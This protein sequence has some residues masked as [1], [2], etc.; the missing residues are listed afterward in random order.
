MAG[1]LGGERPLEAQVRKLVVATR[2]PGKVREFRALLADLPLELLPAEGAPEVQETGTTFA[3][4]AALKARAIARW[5]GCWALGED[6]GIEVDALDGRPG[7][8]S[9]R[10]AGENSTEGE[11]NSRLLELLEG[12]PAERRTARYRAVV[13]IAAPD[14]RL[15]L[16]EGKCEGV[17]LTTP[18]GTGGFGY[19]PLFYLPER[20][21]TMA[22]LPLSEKNRI[23]HRAR[24]MHAARAVL[25]R[26][27]GLTDS[28]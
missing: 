5:A 3:E 14:G 28:E 22:E 23:S 20:G 13:A 4:N 25:E 1:E 2:N 19:D 15:W 7:V 18:R 24:A 10:F 27:C 11:R 8:Y 9:N 21:C 6:S 12:V 17:L 16:L 26:L